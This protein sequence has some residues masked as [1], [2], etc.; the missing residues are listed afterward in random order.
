MWE[1]IIIEPFI[2]ALLFI[3]DLIGENF[4]LSDHPFHSSHQTHLLAIDVKTDKKQPGT[5]R[6]AE[7][8]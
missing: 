5:S 7:R 3:Y 2:N 8:S 1:S 6:N 4:G